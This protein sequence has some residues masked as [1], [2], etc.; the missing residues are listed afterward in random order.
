LE[1]VTFCASADDIKRWGGVPAKT[2]AFHGGFQRALG[3]RYL[4]IQSFFNDGQASPT[5]IVVAF[6][7]GALKVTS[8]GYPPGWVDPTSLTQRPEFC[9]LAFD[10]E[11]ADLDSASL[12]ELRSRVLAMLGARLI[13]PANEQESDSTDP[14]E[15]ETEAVD[16]IEATEEEISGDGEQELDVGQS[17]L[18]RFYDFI[19]DEAAVASWLATESKKQDDVR[20]KEKKT[21]AD[22]E[23]LRATPEEQLKYLLGSLLRPAMIVDGQH[24]VWGANASEEAPITFTVCAIKDADWIE[25][26]FQFVVLNRL[27]KPIS[28]GFLTSILNT[29]L[30]NAEVGQIE[31][32]L[33][34]IGIVNTDRVIMK[35]LNHDTRSPFHGLIAEPGEV[36]GVDNRGKLSDKGMIRLAKRWLNV[37]KSKKEVEMFQRAIGAKN[38]GAARKEW[39]KYEVWVPYFYTFWRAIKA[40]YEKEGVWEKTEGTHLLYIV[41]MH[42]MQE[43]FLEKKAEAD[44]KFVDL[45]D[46]K[47]Q[48]E[49]YFADVPSGFFRGWKAT[50]LQSGDGP[51]WIK[52]AIGRLRGGARLGTVVEES[53]LFQE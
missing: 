12:D 50:G 31:K 24:R 6:R 20:K 42:A 11:Y 37:R 30:T 48:V 52:K 51:E 53:E 35:F 21:L 45:D 39:E 3:N 49:A 28:P 33:D 13:A 26:V 5:S 43:M 19:S 10:V 16:E 4:K 46:F 2:T 25:Q 34:A 38:L 8:L 23:A 1:L 47:A 29:S 27:A 36:A 15:E 22:Q 9:H 14:E 17:K 40:R 7:Q 41:T 44:S 18:R 32:R